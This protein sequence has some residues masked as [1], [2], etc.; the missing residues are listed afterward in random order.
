MNIRQLEPQDAEVYFQIRLEALYKNPEAFGSSYEE[1]KKET[2]DKYKER[3]Q[4]TDSFI[5]GAFDDSKLVGVIT[6]LTEKRMKLKH[7][8]TI[9]AMYVAPEKRGEGVAKALMNEAINKARTLEGI[10]QIHLTVVSSNIAAKK[11]YSSLGF[12][13]YGTEKRALKIEETYLDED[14]MVLFLR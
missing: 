11:L 14:F 3:L 8:A 2:A 4:G 6:L 13:E 1:E 10:E 7:R 5:F 12:E 9:V